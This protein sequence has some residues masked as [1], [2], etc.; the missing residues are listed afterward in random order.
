MPVNSFRAF[1]IAAVGLLGL[2]A[3]SQGP[4]QDSS[5]TTAPVS[6]IV[7]SGARL[8]AGDGSVIDDA[9]FVVDDSRFVA[10]GPAGQVSAPAGAARVDLAGKTVMPAIVDAHV[11]LNTT[12]DA[13]I[14]DLKRRAYFGVGAAISMGS[15]LDDVPLAVRDEVIP[16]AARFR[17]AGKGFARP[18]PGRREV[19]WINSAEEGVAGVREEVA[20]KVDLIKVWVDDRGGQFEKLTPEMYGAI[21]NEAHANGLR[22]AAH[23]FTLEDAK[24][25]LRAG[26]DIFAHGVRDGDIDDDFLGLVAEHPDTILIPNLPA[27]GVPAEYSWLSGSIP[28]GQLATLMNAEPDPAEQEAFGIQAR[29]LDRLYQAGMTI[30]MGTDGNTAWAPH[31]EMEDMVIAGMSPA[32]VIVAAT[33]NS[34]RVLGID[35]IGTIEAGNSA[36]FL[37]LDADPL[38]DITNTRRINAVYLRGEVVDRDAL[39]ASWGTASD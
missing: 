38:D 37:V 30:A 2:A 26:I 7:Y 6:A 25:L 29:N 5:E 39:R 35:D 21:I 12:R 33:R 4:Q 34:A 27:R 15:D 28:D 1:A 20:R 3:C 9:V 17:S 36:D 23:I 14:D 18:E 19:H 10:V 24:G 31:T 22:V 13:L 8:I 32:D 16:G 11:H